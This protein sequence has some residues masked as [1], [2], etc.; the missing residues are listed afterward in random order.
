MNQTTNPAGTP[1][2]KT[3]RAATPSAPSARVAEKQEPSHTE[4]DFMRDLGKTAQQKPA[5]S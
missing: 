3:V 1:V 2:L 4:A 5:T